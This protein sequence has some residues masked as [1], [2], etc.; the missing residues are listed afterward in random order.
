MKACAGINARVQAVPLNDGGGEIIAD[1]GARVH[2]RPG[3]YLECF[4]RAQQHAHSHAS[5]PF[6]RPPAQLG[7]AVFL[8]VQRKL[9]IGRN[10]IIRPRTGAGDRGKRAGDI[11]YSPFAQVLVQGPLEAALEALLTPFEGDGRLQVSV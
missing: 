5:G 7:A 3:I 10:G 8:C 2:I 6:Q 1:V 4:A 11:K 9:V